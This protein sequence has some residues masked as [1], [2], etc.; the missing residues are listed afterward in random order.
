MGVGL[1]A[2]NLIGSG[3]QQQQ[4]ASAATTEQVD[5]ELTSLAALEGDAPVVAAAEWE[6]QHAQ[7]EAS[8]RASSG[9]SDTPQQAQQVGEAEEPPPTYVEGE[10]VRGRRV[11]LSTRIESLQGST[12]P[13]VLSTKAPGAP[14]ELRSRGGQT[15]SNSLL[16]R[17]SQSS[18]SPCS[19]CSFSASVTVLTPLVTVLPP[20]V[21]QYC[22]LECDRCPPQDATTLPPR[23]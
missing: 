11:W 9:G 17:P 4:S 23:L 19:G 12:A 1:L 2:Y 20:R 18:K 3:D 5:N 21:W 13:G 22:P 10:K 8:P 15:F 7:Q 16:L 14:Q 6:S